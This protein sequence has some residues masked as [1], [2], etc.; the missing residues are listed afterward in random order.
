[1]KETKTACHNRVSKYI[2]SPDYGIIRQE[3]TATGVSEYTAHPVKDVIFRGTH[4]KD[5]GSRG[6]VSEKYIVRCTD[7]KQQQIYLIKESTLGNKIKEIIQPISRETAQRV[8]ECST[9]WLCSSISP[10]IRELGVKM[11]TSRFSPDSV[12]GFQRECFGIGGK[13]KITADSGISIRE[14]SSDAFSQGSI[15]ESQTLDSGICL[16]QINYERII[17]EYIASILKLKDN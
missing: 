6:A 14:F 2:N 12:V 1:M 16:L 4:E 9:K 3:L 13:V 15:C 11:T 5:A 8:F 10:L 7:D 17:P